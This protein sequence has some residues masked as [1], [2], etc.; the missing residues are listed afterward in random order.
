MGE[1]SIPPRFEPPHR[2]LMAPGPSTADIRVRQAMAQ[3]VIGHLDPATGQ[4]LNE[5]QAMLRTVFRTDNVLTFP[6]SGT[7]TAGMECALMNVLEPGEVALLVVG[8]AFAERMVEIASRCGAE[9]QVIGGEWGR[10]VPD[11]EVAAA[12]K[13]HPDAKIVGVVHAETSTGVLQPLEGIGELCRDHGAMLVVDAVASLGG[14]PVEV[15]AWGIDVCYSGSQKCLSVPPGLAPITFSERA[16]HVRTNRAT[17]MHSFYLDVLPISQYL[18]SERLYH[19]TAP[20]SMLY[21]LHEGLRMVLEEG[22]DQRWRRHAELGAELL[23]ALQERGF[24]PYAP[25]G[26]RLPEVVCGRLP[27]WV[28]DKPMRRRLLDEFGIEVAGGLGDLAGKVWRLGLMGESCTRDN[29]DAVLSAID[30]LAASVRS[31]VSSDA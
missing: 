27:D 10:P 12:L 29:V 26:H 9:V 25:E 24:D 4:L 2:R 23:A 13:E 7:G 14:I 30:V 22:L 28:D 3:P 18:G 11:S 31:G 15:D 20:I 6:V 17:P 21:G 8:G 5:I 19:H 1:P 16:V